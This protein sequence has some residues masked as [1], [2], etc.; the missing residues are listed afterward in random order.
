MKRRRASPAVC[1]VCGEDVPPRSPACPE[2]GSDHYT[3]WS[4][5]ARLDGL[6]LRDDGFSYEEFMEREIGQP[7]KPAGIQWLWWI[8]ALVLV[9]VWIAY[10]LQA[11]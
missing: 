6:D 11:R 5:R 8:T 2:C 4:G 3:G 7:R 1:P 10:L 9:V